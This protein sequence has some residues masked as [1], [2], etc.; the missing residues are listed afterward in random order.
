MWNGGILQPRRE[1]L[2]EIVLQQEETPA[3]HAFLSGFMFYDSSVCL[4]VKK[5][6]ELIDP[7]WD[8]PAQP[9]PTLGEWMDEARAGL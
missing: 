7:F 2:G 6:N 1:K 4:A 5:F 9:F 3:M 8:L